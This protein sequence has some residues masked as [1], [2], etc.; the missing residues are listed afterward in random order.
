MN[1]LNASTN[2]ELDFVTAQ[3]IYL[4]YLED[5]E[6]YSLSY[7]DSLTLRTIGS[8][9]NSLA[10]FARSIFRVITGE[11]IEVYLTHLNNQDEFRSQKTQEDNQIKVFPNPISDEGFSV[12]IKDF[13]QD[14]NYSIRVCHHLGNVMFSGKILQGLSNISTDWHAGIYFVEISMDGHALL[15]EKLIKL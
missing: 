11:K 9:K 4:D 5:V 7:A 10:G 6:N 8:S 15:K 12:Y 2:E 13:E 14:Q 3:H 1:C